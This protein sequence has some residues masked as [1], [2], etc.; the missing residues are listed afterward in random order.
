M[1]G[2]GD[3]GVTRTELMRRDIVDK[4]TK[5][6]AYAN[7]YL[8]DESYTFTNQELTFCVSVPVIPELTLAKGPIRKY[9]STTDTRQT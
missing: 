5:F 3:I 8:I 7:K 9:Q 1:V 4:D 2:T 6:G